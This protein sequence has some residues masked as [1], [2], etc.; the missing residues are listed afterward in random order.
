SPGRP[1]GAAAAAIPGAERVPDAHAGTD[2]GAGP[3]AVRRAGACAAAA[4]HADPAADAPA[5][6][7]AANDAVRPAA[8]LDRPGQAVTHYYQRRAHKPAAPAR[9]LAGAAGLCARRGP[10]RAHPFLAPARASG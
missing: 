5:G 2:P 3:A 7:G 1:D 8:R 6:S 10:R 4:E 9:A